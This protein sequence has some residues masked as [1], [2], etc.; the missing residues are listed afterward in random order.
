MTTTLDRRQPRQIDDHLP[1]RVRRGFIV[2]S[3]AAVVASSSVRGF[4]APSGRPRVGDVIYGRIESLGQHR[5][6]ENRSGRIHRLDQ[7]LEAVFVYG[8]R[9]ATDA[10]EALV[11]DRHQPVVD[12]VARSGVIGEVRT[13]S[14][15]VAA[16]TRVRVLGRAVGDDNQPINTRRLGLDPPRNGRNGRNGRS[17]GRRSPLVLVVG[18]SMNAGKSTAAIAIAR[19]LISAGRKVRASKLTGTASLKEILHMPDAGATNCHD[20]TSL[21]WP[22]TYLLDQ[23]EVLGIF[24]WLD[25]RFANNPANHWVCEVA[26][27]VL[28]REVAILLD[29]AIVRSRLDRL[30]LCASDPCS[31]LG[32]LRTLGERFGLEVDAVSEL[33]GS[34]PLGRRE[35][36]QETDVPV[37]DSIAPDLGR[38]VRMLA[39][40]ER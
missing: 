2:P 24:D 18:T 40:V 12:L 35:L 20:F 34:S 37:F 30:V 32:G 4:V 33:V 8:N 11:P 3:A 36:E 6:L 25:C 14:R 7:G 16:P 27:G 26:D 1:G 17:G 5:E 21:G 31:A 10:Y 29:S 13:S 28:Q 15:L 38:L 39:D 23:A 19:A 22:S 9:Y